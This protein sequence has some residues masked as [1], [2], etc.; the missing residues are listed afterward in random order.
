MIPNVKK[1]VASRA[2]KK[3]TLSHV[4]LELGWST[5]GA[6][7]G[8]PRKSTSNSRN[9]TGRNAMV[10]SAARFNGLAQLA[11]VVWNKAERTMPACAKPP[12]NR[13]FTNN[14]V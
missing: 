9:E 7:V 10:A 6:H 4:S 13:K 1:A 14:T 3:G 8:I 12:K 2:T 11:D 5:H